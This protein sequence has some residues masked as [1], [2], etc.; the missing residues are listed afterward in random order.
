MRIFY[1]L[2]S[3]VVFGTGCFSA[4]P[5]V[6]ALYKPLF[7]PSQFVAT[8]TATGAS[9]IAVKAGASITNP[10]VNGLSMT[11]P[12][13][14][15]APNQ[16]LANDGAGNWY[17]SSAGAGLG[18]VTSVGLSAPGIFTVSGSP[19]VTSGTLALALANQTAN[20]VWAGPVSG[21]AAPPTFR[22]MVA[23]D[24]P[25]LFNVNQLALSGS[26]LQIIP[27]V[28]LT[29]ILAN[30]AVLSGSTISGIPYSFLANTNA[31]L[32]W[33][34]NGAGTV[35]LTADAGSTNFLTISTNGV[36]LF[37]G[38]AETAKFLSGGLISLAGVPYHFPG[39]PAAGI[40]H[41]DGNNPS[42]IT[43]SAVD[44]SGSEATGI[45][46]AG[47]FPALTGD[48]TTV[49]GALG[50]TFA[51]V[52]TP[53]TATKVTY[54]AKGLVTSGT[55]A[56]LTSDFPNQGTTT[57]LLH[58]NAAGNLSF[59]SV[60]LANDVSGNLGVTHL[61]SGTSSS[62]ATFWRGD[63]VWATPA[64]GGNVSGT[65]TNNYMTYWD[66]SS[67]INS[68]PILLQ[69]GALFAGSATLGANITNTSYSFLANTNAGLTYWTNA[70]GTVALTADAGETN[71]LTISTNGVRLFAGSVETAKFLSGGHISFAGVPYTWPGSPAAGIMH[72]S[73]ANPS[74]LTFSAV[75]LSGSD[76]TG[77]LSVSHLNSGT[78]A[79]AGSYWRGDGVWG[80]PSANLSGGGAVNSL[81]MWSSALT[82]TNSLIYYGGINMTVGKDWVPT[83]DVTL[84]LGGSANRWLKL[85]AQDADFS[86][87][88]ANINGA[89]YV[90]PTTNSLN[91]Q[92]LSS[93]SAGNLYWTNG[94]VTSSGT[95]SFI[96]R[97][98]STST[99]GNSRL[100]DSG[101]QAIKTSASIWPT[102]A[103]AV[104]LGSLSNPWSA[105]S[106]LRFNGEGTNAL[107]SSTPIWQDGSYHDAVIIALTDTS[108]SSDSAFLTLTNLTSGKGFQVAKDGNVSWLRGVSYTWPSSAAA[109]L[110]HS[111][112]ATP[113]VLSFSAVGLSGA[114]VTG[115]LGVSHLNSGSSASSATVWRGDATWAS[116]DLASMVSGN[117]GVSHLNSGT[118]ASS[119]T[120]WR[121][122]GTWG[123][124]A[125]APDNWVPIGTTNS[126]LSGNAYPYS[127]LVSDGSSS[128]YTI[129][130]TNHA[131]NG[132]Y[133][134]SGRTHIRGGNGAFYVGSTFSELNF[135]GSTV[136][137]FF[138][139]GMEIDL[140]GMSAALA[141]NTNGLAYVRGVPYVWPLTNALAGQVFASDASG[142]LYWT[143]F[144]AATGVTGSGA[145]GFIPVWT[146]SGAI[147]NSGSLFQ[148][149]SF[150]S[151]KDISPTNDLSN[152]I[153]GPVNRWGAFY[154][155]RGL[156][157]GSGLAGPTGDFVDVQGSWND[158]TALAD[159]D[160]LKVNVTDLG[161]TN[162]SRLFLLQNGGTNK[163]LV[164]KDGQVTA[165]GNIIPDT[166]LTYNLGNSSFK[167]S[168]FRGGD[169]TL[170]GKTLTAS[171]DFLE[172]KSV[173]WNA[174]S[175]VMTAL[176]LN[177]TDTTSSQF[178]LLQDLEVGGLGVFQ[179]R[180]DGNLGVI[181]GTVYT[182]PT[183]NAL[184]GQVLA[185]TSGG[186]LYWTN[187]SGGGGASLDAITAD[188]ASSG[189]DNTTF[190]N[191]WRFTN[192]TAGAS[193]FTLKFGLA[194]ATAS[195]LTVTEDAAGTGGSGSQYLANFATLASSTAT[196][197]R[198]ATRGTE[199]LRV[200][201]SGVQLLAGQSTSA[202]PTYSFAG[203]TTGGLSWNGASIAVKYDNNNLITYASTGVSIN[204]GGSLIESVTSSGSQITKIGIGVAPDATRPLSVEM[205][206]L[207]VTPNAGIILSN[208]TAAAAG[209]QQVSPGVHWQG[210]GWKTT[211]TA[212]SQPVEFRA[213]VLPVQGAANPSSQWN[214]D[215]SIN[216]GSF[217]NAININS[218]GNFMAT[219]NVTATGS[220]NAGTSVTLGTS[221]AVYFNNR[222]YFDATADGV[223]RIRDNAGAKIGAFQIGPYVV[224]KP[225]SYT[226]VALDSGTTFQ[227]SNS[228][229]MV[230]YTLPTAV[231]GQNFT[232]DVV[233]N[234]GI[235]I[236]AAGSD[237]IRF[238]QL[239]TGAAGGITNNGTV[240]S[241]VHIKCDVLQN[242]GG[243]QWMVDSSKGEWAVSTA[244]AGNPV[245]LPE[246]PMVKYLQ[247]TGSVAVASQTT[248]QPEAT[249]TLPA[250]AS[251]K[252]LVECSGSFAV[253]GG[254]IKLA[255]SVPASASYVQMEGEYTDDTL[256]TVTP[257]NNS[258][259]GS[260]GQLS[261]FSTTQTFAGH[262][263]VRG[264][265]E[266]STTAGAIQLFYAQTTSNASG[267]SPVQ[268]TYLKV[269]PIN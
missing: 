132:I 218:A 112:G 176:K 38:S 134:N 88:V 230:V 148:G 52:A 106:S 153:G 244:T 36:R 267:C 200:K 171:T 160:A 265:L 131:T 192:A 229:A 167:W 220:L 216:G 27:G 7:D 61:N 174:P 158:G 251:R 190:T 16:F 9:N 104:E 182:W 207:L 33:W 89:A 168:G 195:G 79:N 156:F 63:G 136:F 139:L 10:A 252:Y 71:F 29:N 221:S 260:G 187:S 249:L 129:G 105:V 162:T 179:V 80:I 155:T 194:N 259:S 178:S 186:G 84:N 118:S 116:V 199:V 173:T 62:A 97:F 76:V 48:A 21:P 253:G 81:A 268:G 219:G 40:F 74:I 262:F 15:S 114:D 124:P 77:N 126:A 47:R 25:Y 110:L 32:T 206:N 180:K 2:L 102:N 181:R 189:I 13:T 43:F 127:V 78:G 149:S 46:A 224:N 128:F 41:A 240:G 157:S 123:T 152:N 239:V 58:G 193:S 256:S 42:A 210:Q 234:F 255:M 103:Y 248:F 215:A 72:A 45:L 164:R 92:Q 11:W 217:V 212:A 3:V 98:T 245:Y 130:F 18:T 183:T 163:F 19:V 197:L 150:Y 261:L 17:Y 55:A 211:A 233:T 56:S 83:N 65:G 51:T 59:A 135:S 241:S 235:T 196:P 146:S 31:G 226:V 69:G 4:T 165:S 214:L 82:L 264:I 243:G 141:V 204:A 91:N 266:N 202:A 143:N 24:L 232:F 203:L 208:V 238:G 37:A 75:D 213:Y 109:G 154:G 227:N 95:T 133:W 12:L 236:V 96:P 60:D 246:E 23:G 26:T 250:L 67:T 269:T 64:G 86:G 144:S 185:S 1:A 258:A 20:L 35:V 90:W 117:L 184:S 170:S 188:V 159:L 44:L 205:D 169:L 137:D 113:S 177:V 222:G 101:V 209:A 93:D 107:I 172:N 138:P 6:P 108:S 237:V 121:G 73:G 49:A 191:A 28:N 254:G 111:D 147:G 228:T 115:N 122:D 57:T 166:D 231:V 68:S 87:N 50:I 201:E 257:F 247:G 39:S 161:S 14:N 242:G 66:S 151:T 142:N 53:G 8:P 34:T 5:P 223:F 125:G 119:S 85:W 120:F 175:Q 54:N 145:T 99:I 70:A 198:I 94:T 22:A 100:F 140:A 225:T 263:S 30:N